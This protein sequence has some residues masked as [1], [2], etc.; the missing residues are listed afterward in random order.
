MADVTLRSK[1]DG[2][3][4]L[5][6]LRVTVTADEQPKEGTPFNPKKLTKLTVAGVEGAEPIRQIMA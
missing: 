3:G 4:A 6:S 2:N 1:N 5:V